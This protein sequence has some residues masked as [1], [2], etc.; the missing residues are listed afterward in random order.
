MNK[1]TEQELIELTVVY[2]NRHNAC[3]AAKELLEARAELV[4]IKALP[5]VAWNVSNQHGEIVGLCDT[6]DVAKLLSGAWMYGRVIPLIV[7]PTEG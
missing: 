6:E 3:R 1:L 7:K 5:P 4:A 2:G